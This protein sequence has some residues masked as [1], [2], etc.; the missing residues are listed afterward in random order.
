MSKLELVEELHRGARRNYPRRKT[1]MR[2]IHDTIQAD[3]VEMIPHAR[4]NRNMKYILV[5]INIFSKKAYARPIKSKSGP[6]VMQALK[7]ILD[8]L[9]HPIRLLHV[10]M[11]KEFYNKSVQR[12]LK[13]RHIKLYST[14]SVKKAS[15]VERFNRT[16]K[17]KMWKRF[18]FNGSYKW[19]DLL[20]TLIDEYNN[21]MHRT[22]HM[23]P[24]EVCVDNER[25]LL[26]T[27]YR[28]KQPI[29]QRAKYKPGDLVRMSKH[30]H[31]F[32]KGYTPNWTTEVFRITRVLNTSPITYRIEDLEGNEINGAIYTEELQR[33]NNPNLYLVERIERKR[34]ARA[35]VKWLGFSSAHNSWIDIVDLI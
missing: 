32:E 18:S 17:S 19:V 6:D 9:G 24:N 11:G 28:Y 21:T 16:L 22:I 35:L 30:K 5:A 29:A 15:I 10:D 26:D 31:V 13:E 4:A 27:V 1:R 25:L 3:L 8:S 14:F 33:A 7:S 2:G 34:G 20:A 12:M 23:T